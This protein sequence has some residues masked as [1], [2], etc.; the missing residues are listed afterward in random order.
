MLFS[1]KIWEQPIVLMNS[2]EWAS[3]HRAALAA[4]PHDCLPQPGD[5]LR[6]A[7]A[8]GRDAPASVAAAGVTVTVGASPDRPE[9]QQIACRAVRNSRCPG[10]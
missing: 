1:C 8:A 3:V 6:V 7:G 9:Q 10:T 4:Q 2:V 5:I